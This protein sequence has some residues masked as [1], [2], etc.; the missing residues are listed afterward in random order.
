[1]DTC[2]PEVDPRV[3]PVR[4]DVEPIPVF[5]LGH[6]LELQE[7]VQYK[8]ALDEADEQGW[9]PLHEA[10]VQ[11]IQQILETVLDGK[12]TRTPLDTNREKIKK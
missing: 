12:R 3:H 10:V 6:I 2:S 5:C 9:F 8:Y 7:Y 11:P 4:T 1:M